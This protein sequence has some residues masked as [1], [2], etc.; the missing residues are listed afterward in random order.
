MLTRVRL[1]ARSSEETFTPINKSEVEQFRTFK[2][3][4]IRLVI[5][6]LEQPFTSEVM[7]VQPGKR[8]VK[9]KETRSL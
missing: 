8:E 7:K 3:L 2:V 9:I 4:F 5:R 1:V 6:R